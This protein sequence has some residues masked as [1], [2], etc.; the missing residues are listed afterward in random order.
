MNLL[1][2][3]SNLSWVSI[4]I[5]LLVIAL[6]LGAAQC[7]AECIGVS[8]HETIQQASESKTPPC[9]GK[10]PVNEGER[11]P[12]CQHSLLAVADAAVPVTTTIFTN[13]INLDLAERPLYL[14]AT[15]IPGSDA[16]ISVSPPHP[17]PS[18][19]SVVLRI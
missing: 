13:D 5:V 4:N 10:Q 17:V 3:N 9:H 16:P 11:T 14:A 6:A 2:R 18:S 19:W 8:C 1:R 7:A 15:K 12:V